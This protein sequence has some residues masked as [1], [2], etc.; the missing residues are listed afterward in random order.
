VCLRNVEILSLNVVCIERIDREQL[1]KTKIK[2][3]A[4]CLLMHVVI[5][6]RGSLHIRNW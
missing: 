4:V 1:Y 5:L 2:R 3:V 6:L